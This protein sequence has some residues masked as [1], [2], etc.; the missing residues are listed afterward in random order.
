MF[1]IWQRKKSGTRERLCILHAGQHK[2]G[3]TTLQNFLTQ[4]A[5]R[6][7]RDGVLYPKAGRSLAR[8]Q[9]VDLLRLI[10]GQPLFSSGDGLIEAF[11]EEIAHTDHEVLLLSSEFLCSPLYFRPN[12]LVQDFLTAR[13]YRLHGV[14]YLRDQPEYLNSAYAER[15]K[16]G[17][18]HRPFA[19][20]AEGVLTGTISGAGTAMEFHRLRR[21]E[22][23]DWGT[24]TFRPYSR[25]VRRNGVEAD[26]METLL[27][28]LAET[29]H[30]PGLT[31]ERVAG[32]APAE[33]ANI[34]TG[35]LHIAI[36]RR[37]AASLA[38][39]FDHRTL[40]RVTEG[41]YT[42]IHEMLLREGI[43]ERSYTGLTPEIYARIRAHYAHRNRG[44]GREFWERSWA[45]VFP[46]LP[47]TRLVTNDLD[48]DSPRGPAG[49]QE[50]KVNRLF[51]LVMPEIEASVAAALAALPPEPASQD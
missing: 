20:F 37:V 32:F 16:M 51:R 12:R 22:V 9:H 7:Q 5:N 45:R 11:D 10:A 49:R 36:G 30:A 18:E 48:L 21:P 17:R 34:S 14:M 3:S 27:G 39:R 19:E 28:I 41:V 29:G 44:V 26:F 35:P 40:V 24:Q 4:N 1:N 50:K 13:G 15:V 31:A 38:P 46:A 8:T 47:A 2:T 23:T 6:L 42:V 43:S 33:R 25:A